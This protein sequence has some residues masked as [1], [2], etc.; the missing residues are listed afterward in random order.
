[1]LKLVLCY[2]EEFFSFEM[3]I[4][5]NVCPLVKI[6]FFDM[7][8]YDVPNSSCA[9]LA[10][11]THLFIERGVHLHCILIRDYFNFVCYMYVW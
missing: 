6:Y 5:P 2:Y 9:C 4:L 11:Y 8:M 3:S 7:R 1:M 10:G